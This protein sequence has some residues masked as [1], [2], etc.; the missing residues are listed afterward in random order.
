[1][2]LIVFG[3]GDIYNR[4]K[5]RISKEDKVIAALDNN[6]LLQGE[7]LDG[8]MV[9]HPMEILKLKYD[10]VIIM[11][12][13]A[14]EM[15]KQ[16]LSLGVDKEKIQHYKEFLCEQRSGKFEFFCSNRNSSQKK[17]CLII[18]SF[19]GYHGG[20]I[21]ASYMAMALN[22]KG[23][24]AVIAAPDGDRQ[25]IEEFNEK[26][27][28][29]ILYD[30][31]QFPIANELDWIREYDSII[32]NTY[33][34]ILCALEII[35]FR[36]AILWLHESQ[37]SLEMMSFWKDRV[38]KYISNDNLII[39]AVSKIAKNNFTKYVS[40]V[41]CKVRIL[42]FGIPDERSTISVIKNQKMKFAVVGSIIP[43]KQ[44][45]LFLEAVKMLESQYKSKSEFFV[46]GKDVDPE[47]SKQVG[48]LAMTLPN[49]YVTGELSRVEMEDVYKMMD[50][51]VV[52]STQEPMSIVAVEAM[53]H[54]KICIV[55][56]AAGMYEFVIPEYNGLVCQAGNINS[57]I[58]QMIYCIENKEKLNVM[59]TNARKLYEENFKLD[60][61]GS[62]WEKILS[63]LIP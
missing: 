15:K 31:L 7:N 63:A 50:V 13:Y 18:T 12:D 43:I 23:Y 39:Y 53:M 42:P 11:S 16:L 19:L 3:V 20:A 44:Q 41:T 26:G 48:K 40:V 61:L 4:F 30:N 25:F 62:R 52:P 38:E 8:I 2:E 34:M 49:V 29:F 33:P 9:C 47:Y 5:E 51:L 28:D 36:K 14:L 24:N 21:V 57:L 22:M 56:N 6:I 37:F 45:L 58:K 10:K 35:K 1:M 27:I 60:V 55:S 32:V 46:I 59:K 17:K 54:E